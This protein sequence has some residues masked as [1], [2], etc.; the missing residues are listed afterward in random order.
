MLLYYIVHCINT[1]V[2]QRYESV[3]KMQSKMQA[4]VMVIIH[5]MSKDKEVKRRVKTLKDYYD[6]QKRHFVKFVK[7]K[8]ILNQ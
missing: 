1:I 5:S 7:K 2:P 3:C 8:K 6:F 4:K